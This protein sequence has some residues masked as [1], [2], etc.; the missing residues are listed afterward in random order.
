MG[1]MRNNAQYTRAR[2]IGLDVP[3]PEG[4]DLRIWFASSHAQAPKG[5]AERYTY[6]VVYTLPNAKQMETELNKRAAEGW[7]LAIAVSNNQFSDLCLIFRKP[8]P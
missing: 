2:D 1:F 3:V 8:A 7:E 6:L 4:V 5:A